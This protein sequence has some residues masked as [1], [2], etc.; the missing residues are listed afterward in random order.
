MVC[1]SGPKTLKRGSERLNVVLIL[2]MGMLD[3]AAFGIAMW[4]ASCLCVLDVVTSGHS[5]MF[6]S[7]NITLRG[8]SDMGS[9]YD[10]E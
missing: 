4:Q 9:I 3:M 8:C 2:Q 7:W 1:L 6:K 10:D 5:S